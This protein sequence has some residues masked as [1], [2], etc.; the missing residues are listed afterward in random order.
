MKIHAVKS[1]VRWNKF[2][3]KAQRRCSK[4]G[5]SRKKYLEMGVVHFHWETGIGRSAAEAIRRYRAGAALICIF[6]LAEREW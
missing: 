1:G 3:R 6:N 4:G 5:S 2:C